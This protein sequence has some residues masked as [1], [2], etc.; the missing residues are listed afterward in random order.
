MILA[1]SSFFSEAKEKAQAIAES[2][3]V[4]AAEVRHM[5]A[6]DRLARQAPPPPNNDYRVP[7]SE[8]IARQEARFRR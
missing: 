8:V 1:E 2:M 4:E 5:E 6:I 7:K 3:S